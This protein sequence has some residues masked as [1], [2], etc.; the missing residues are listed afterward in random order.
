MITYTEGDIENAL[1][2]L[3]QGLALAAAATRHGVPRNTL[4]GRRNGAQLHRYAH[5][6]QQ[7][8]LAI[9]EDKLEQWILRQEALDYVSTHV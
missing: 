9:Q 1:V 7:R 5:S 6:D 4:W 3:E 8:L 2:D